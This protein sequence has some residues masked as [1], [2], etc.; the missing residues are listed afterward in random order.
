MPWGRRNS[1]ACGFDLPPVF[2]LL[3]FSHED[4]ERK[5]RKLKGSLDAQERRLF[6]ANLGDVSQTV[7]RVK[8]TVANE[9]AESNRR[10]EERES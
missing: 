4:Q 3:F 5:L 2:V 7:E 6:E 1:H 10:N 9:L 8:S